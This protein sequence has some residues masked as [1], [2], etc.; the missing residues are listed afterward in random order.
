MN[1]TDA[2]KLQK[3]LAL[4]LLLIIISTFHFNVQSA[5]GQKTLIVPDEYSTIAEAVANAS[6]NDYR[7][8][9]VFTYNQ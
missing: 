8:F 2:A 9:A 6:S 5:H 1:L 3:Y 7:V 4:F